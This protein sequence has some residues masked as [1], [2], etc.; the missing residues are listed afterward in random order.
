MKYQNGIK[1]ETHMLDV[2]D[3]LYV[4]S[5]ELEEYKGISIAEIDPVRSMVTFSNGEVLATGEASG[6]VNEDDMRRIQIRETII[7]H[8]ERKKSCLSRVSSAFLSSL[9]TK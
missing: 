6:N 5:K 8:F 9:S 2:G 4:E 7:S 3:S 1:R